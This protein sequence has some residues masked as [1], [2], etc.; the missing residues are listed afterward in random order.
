MSDN[1]KLPKEAE[2]CIRKYLGYTGKF[3]CESWTVS[4]PA[5][6]KQKSPDL[7]GAKY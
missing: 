7:T 1:T 4:C 2:V 6:L 3:S 5:F